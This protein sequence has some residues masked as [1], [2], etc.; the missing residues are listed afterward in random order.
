MGGGEVEGD[1]RGRR[2]DGVGGERVWSRVEGERRN[3]R[4][5]QR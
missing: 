2:G 1:G 5:K 4:R 3:E